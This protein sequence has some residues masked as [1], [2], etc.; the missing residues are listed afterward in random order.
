MCGD[1]PYAPPPLSET[2]ANLLEIIA[3]ACEEDD[4][5]MPLAVRLGVPD[6]LMPALESRFGAAIDAEV[7]ALL[8]Q[9]SLDLRVNES[10]AN[11]TLFLPNCV[12][13]VS[14]PRRRRSRRPAFASKD[15][16]T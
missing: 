16:R 14:R 10:R 4:A 7:P 15:D 8:G 6:W 3:A 1:G 5:A 9:A 13:W 2:E 11:G 12:H